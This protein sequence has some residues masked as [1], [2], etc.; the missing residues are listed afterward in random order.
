M[1]D[2]LQEGL[3]VAI[4]GMGVVFAALGALA[5]VLRLFGVFLRRTDHMQAPD[6]ATTP[7]GSVAVQTDTSPE[8]AAVVAAVLAALNCSEG[9]VRVTSVSRADK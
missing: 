6:D 4:L 5:F 8:L 7:Q 2:A 1:I 3:K 9:S